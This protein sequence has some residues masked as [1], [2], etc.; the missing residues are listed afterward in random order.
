MTFPL[1]ANTYPYP[2]DCPE[3]GAIDAARKADEAGRADVGV[4]NAL[5]E[6]ERILGG[7]VWRGRVARLTRTQVLV[8]GDRSGAGDPLSRYWRESGYQLEPAGSPYRY[9]RLRPAVKP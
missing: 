2:S 9:R 4:G 8:R 6:L 7:V 5:C 3:A 1:I